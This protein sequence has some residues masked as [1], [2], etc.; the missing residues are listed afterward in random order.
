MNGRSWIEGDAVGHDVDRHAEPFGGQRGLGLVLDDRPGQPR[1]ILLRRAIG[2]P[3]P[4]IV[5]VALHRAEIHLARTDIEERHVQQPV[6]QQHLVLWNDV[7]EHDGLRRIGGHPIQEFGHGRRGIDRSGR[8]QDEHG[9]TGRFQ[10]ASAGRGK[11]GLLLEHGR[12]DGHAFR[13]Q[14]AQQAGCAADWAP[15]R[16]KL[17]VT[18][19]SPRRGRALRWAW[20]AAA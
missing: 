14:P 4:W 8:R 6:G 15:P 11:G 5:E 17:L 9:N 20:I 10:P 1:A 16:E 18:S 2:Q 3:R 19:Q 13:L 12:P 7:P